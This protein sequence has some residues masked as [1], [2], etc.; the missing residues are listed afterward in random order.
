MLGMVILF[1]II[2][3]TVIAYVVV[4]SVWRITA[5]RR[6]RLFAVAIAVL[7]PSWDAVLSGVIYY[8]SCPF[9]PKASIYETAKTDGIFYEGPF[10]NTV[11]IG[12]NRDGT[13]INW[14]APASNDDIK[15]GYQYMEFLVTKKHDEYR[16]VTS[17]SRPVIYRCIEDKSDRIQ[18]YGAKCFPVEGAKSEYLVKS[19]IYSFALLKIGF[20]QIYERT[21]GRLMAEYREMRKYSDL[22]PFFVWLRW[23]GEPS[24]LVPCPVNSQ[25]DTFQY[26]VLKVRE[27]SP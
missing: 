22:L 13:L 5:D 15:R 14:I 23:A 24:T 8:I 9:F 4:R 11:Y 16:E 27:S 18:N 26:D 19:D 6:L 12:V 10:R 17:L 7:I 25:F 3:Y 1:F 21:T 2:L 20:V